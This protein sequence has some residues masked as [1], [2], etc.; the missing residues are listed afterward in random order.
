MTYNELG[1]LDICPDL[2]GNWF[3]IDQDRD[4]I[5]NMRFFIDKEV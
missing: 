3:Y 2:I 4:H 5:L 1:G